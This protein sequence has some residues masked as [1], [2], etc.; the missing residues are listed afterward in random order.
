MLRTAAAAATAV[1][2]GSVSGSTLATAAPGN[3]VDLGDVGLS[4][5]DDITPYLEDYCVGGNEVH[6]PEGKYRWDGR[7]GLGGTYDGSM[8]LIGDGNGAVLDIGDGNACDFDIRTGSSAGAIHVKFQNITQVG[9]IGADGSRMSVA[10]EADDSLI[11]FNRFDRPDGCEFDTDATGAYVPSGH[12][13]TIRFLNCHFEHFS[14]NG[15]Y[16]SSPGQGDGGDG[17]GTIEV[18]GGLWK[19]NNIGNIRIGTTDSIIEGVTIYNDGS[20]PGISGGSSNEM[21]VYIREPGVNM[22]INDCDITTVG[23]AANCVRIADSR[24]NNSRDGDLTVTNTRIRH[25]QSPS[26]VNVSG[27]FGVGGDTIDLTGDGDLSLDG[28]GPWD[29][30][31]RNSG[32]AAPT[33][34]RRWYDSDGSDSGGSTGGSSTAVETAPAT[35]VGESGATLEGNLNDLGDAA[36]AEVGFEYRESGA[37]SWTA[38]ATESLTSTG[39][40]SQ[41]VT[42]LTSETEYE[43]RAV[44]TTGDGTTVTGSA[45]TFSTLMASL[46][47]HLVVRTFDDS[48][49]SYAF[50]TTGLARAGPESEIGNNDSVTDN[51]DGTYTVEGATGSG[52]TDDWYFDGGVTAWADEPDPDKATGDF[53]LVLNGTVVSV[54]ELLGD[55]EAVV[56]TGA[57]TDVGE[58]SA[59]LEGSLTDLGD[60]ASADVGFEYRESGA[61]S[62]TATATESLTSTGTFSRSVSDLASETDYE[63][64]A[65]AT[66]SDGDTGTGSVATFATGAAADPSTGPVVDRFSVTEGGS[67]N[68][69]ADITARWAVSDSDAD[70]HWVLVQ[71]LDQN[72][73]VLDASRTVV[74]GDSA[75]DFDYFRIKRADGQTFQVRIYAVDMA[76]NWTE[77]GDTV[78]E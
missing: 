30:V 21:S 11:E 46:E 13:G 36:S 42:D 62:W 78:T 43:Y 31:C 15:L 55:T 61:S 76:G 24:F 12:A 17:D 1:G 41:S 63:Y 69:H 4:P 40:F 10:A 14:N 73:N 23:S 8:F 39:A 53:E 59:T 52:F 56:E 60:A 67:P 64:R 37:S 54:D 26:V 19:N 3:R 74:S 27:S 75:S 6:I 20:G 50:T 2:L 7:S 33:T 49:L 51:G 58:A 9:R 5:G 18:L 48:G 77:D 71:V 65:V 68:P 22:R 38:T 16:A 66:A 72:D 45:V 28:E 70:L 34:E 47:N 57:A 44:A 35:D 32:C 29:G 25:D